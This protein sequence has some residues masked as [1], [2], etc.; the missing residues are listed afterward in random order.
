[1]KK[2][3]F[4]LFL[5]LSSNVIWA[6]HVMG[7]EITWQCTGGNTYQFQLVFYRDC[8]GAEVN[9]VSETIRVWNHP[10]LTNITLPFVY[11]EDI[12]PSCTEVMGSPAMLEC[13]IGSAG[14][15]GIGAIEKVVYQSAEITISGVPPAAGWIFTYENFS[16]SGALT[17]LNDPSSYGITVAAKM[18]ESPNSISNSCTD[19]SPQFLQPPY[20]ATCAGSEYRYNMNAVDPDLDSLKFEFGVPYDHFPT[21]T[22][23]P[24][25]NPVPVPFE[26]NFSYDSPTPGTL[27]D[28]NNIAATINEANGE[29]IFTSFTSGNFNIKVTV[30]SYRQGNLVSEVEREMQVV[31]LPCSDDNEAPVITAPFPGNSFEVDVIAGDL[32][33]FDLLASDFDLL[34]DGSSQNVII[35]PSGPMFGNGFTSNIGCDIEPCATLNS[36]PPISAPQTVSTVF[37][38]ETTCDHLINQFGEVTDMIPYDFVFKVQDDFCQI[39]KITYST[40]RINVINSGVLDAPKISCIQTD[41]S[42]NITIYWNE[43]SDPNGTF[44]EYGIYSVEDGLIANIADIT[45]TNFTINGITGSQNYFLSTTS[46]ACG[47]SLRFSDTIANIFLSIN[48]PGNGTALLNWNN[49]STDFEPE[50]NNYSR[51]FRE[52]PVGSLELIDSVPFSVNNYKDTIDICQAFL[53]YRIELPTSECTYTSNTI[54]DDFEDMLT[55]SIPLIVSVGI[56]TTSNNMMIQWDENNQ[57]DTYGY[58][59]YTF[60][61]NGILFE[62]DTIWGIENTSYLY[63]VNLNEGPYSYSVA[64]F[65]SCSTNTTPVTFQTSAKASIN[66]S[67]ISSSEVYMCEQEADIFWTPYI[68][69]DVD[70]YEIWSLIGGVWNLEEISQDTTVRI[71]VIGNQNYSIY[72]N[73]VF[74]D[75]YN[76]FSSPTLFNVPTAGQPAFHYFMLATV[77]DESIEL[78]DYVD[79]SVGITEIIFQRKTINGAYEEIGRS[80]ANTNQVFF[81]DEDANPSYRSWEYRTKYIDSCGNEGTFANENKTI[82]LEGSANEYDMINSINWSPYEGFD[83]GILEYHIYRSVNGNYDSSPIAV[84]DPSELNY[85]DDVSTT[86]SD[87]KICY[88]I[89][90]VEAFNTYNFSAVSASNELCLLYSP[91]IYI[92]N[93]FTPNGM[94]PIFRPIVSNIE[95]STYHLTI[96]NRWGQ[97]VFESFDKNDGWNGTIQSNGKKATNDVY[98]YVFE[99][100][101]ETGIPILKRGFVSLIE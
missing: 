11:R 74:F 9:I 81:L 15:N 47:N 94:N 76:A 75:G 27:T 72:I 73:A 56:D 41:D 18:F 66:T 37:N 39:P 48:N 84:L 13:G 49:P 91:R 24:P 45:T 57:N 87:G 28:P 34:Q 71:P 88:R 69:R 46:G 51:I 2:L 8:N 64:A 85:A 58:I 70:F 65:D 4:L 93:A 20:F 79:E 83:G 89:E 10:T 16:R 80:D 60:D 23:D 97:K 67:M 62:L 59:I 63:P 43:V 32:I 50:F 29:L 35:T 52:Y 53:S 30:K 68:G 92:P 17:N 25:N 3:A 77:N 99:A 33:S 90:A 61:S 36:V 55:P 95:F 96:I 12:S 6:S 82:F 98:V 44:I 42:D 31:V 40:V 7:G 38:W 21:G 22:Y 19:S 78:Y 26:S 86:E 1:M 100:Q 14:G 5:L 54:G 101:D